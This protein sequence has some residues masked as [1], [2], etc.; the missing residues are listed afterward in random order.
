MPAI[1]DLRPLRQTK[2]ITLTQAATAFGVW[3]MH[4][5]SIERGTRRDD[6]LATRYREWLR[7]AP[8]FRSSSTV[9]GP[10]L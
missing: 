8:D 7:Q 9:P 6:D 10:A 5:S 4:I 2:N 3:P 1:D